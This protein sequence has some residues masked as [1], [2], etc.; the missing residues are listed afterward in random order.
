VSSRAIIRF[1]SFFLFFLA[2]N[3]ACEA[4]PKKPDQ[5]CLGVESD[6]LP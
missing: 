6:L 4:L 3:T 5:F 2:C 1:M